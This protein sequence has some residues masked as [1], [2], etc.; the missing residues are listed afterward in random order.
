MCAPSAPAAPNYQQ[1]AQTQGASNIQTAIAQNIMNQRNQ[2]TPL[3]SLTY[4]QTGTQTV[5]GAEGNPAVDVP[6]YSSNVSLSPEGQQIYGGQVKQAQGMTNLA[7][8]SLDQTQSAL[9]QPFNMGDVNKIADQ[10]Y[11]AQTARLDPQWAANTTSEE[12]KLVNQG[13]RPGDEAYNN[14]MR[15]FDQGKN[16]AYS[17]ARLNAIQTMPQTFQLGLAGRQVPLN[18]LN[19]LRTGSQVQMPSFAA[20]PPTNMQAPN[21]QQ[22]AGQ[23]GAWNQGLYN[24]QVGGQNALMGG[25]FNMGAAALPLLL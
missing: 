24:A 17:Q 10:S 21:Y 9:G 12:T 25:L 14:A 7:N 13:L 5:P 15:V 22:V 6:T 3:G 23:Q 11:A 16:D 19:A 2:N 1:A 4:Q 8:Q 20:P 18:E